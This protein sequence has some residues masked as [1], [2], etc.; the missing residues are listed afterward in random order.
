MPVR[1]SRD[2]RD[3]LSRQGTVIA[4]L[5]IDWWGYKKK[6]RRLERE[7]GELRRVVDGLE[8]QNRRNNVI[9]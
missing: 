1:E 5:R 2:R 4:L 8:N 3:Y 7:N 6:V 9:M